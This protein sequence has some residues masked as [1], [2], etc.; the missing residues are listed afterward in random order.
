MLES[1]ELLVIFNGRQWHLEDDEIFTFG[2][3]E[4]CTLRLDP[5]DTAISRLAGEIRQVDGIWFLTNRSTSRPLPLA[6]ESGLRQ[7]LGPGRRDVVEGTLRVL[8]EGREGRRHELVLHGPPPPDGDPE[9]GAPGTA[10]ASGLEV[11]LSLDDRR[12]LAALFVGYLLE[13]DAYDPVPRTYRS[14]AHRVGC[15]EKALTKRVDYIRARLTRAGVPRLTDY[16]AL[17]ALAEHVLANRLIT[18]EDLRLIGL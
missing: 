13:G 2:R 3:S 14:A 6:D 15:G 17:N 9:H 1:G 12:A 16:G 18:R 10:T 5:E 4:I 8:V 7:L 11:R